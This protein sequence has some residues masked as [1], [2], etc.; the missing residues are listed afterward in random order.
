MGAMS[1]RRSVNNHMQPKLSRRRRLDDGV[2]DDNSRENPSA[3]LL[4]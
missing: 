4:A 1:K 2:D 3:L